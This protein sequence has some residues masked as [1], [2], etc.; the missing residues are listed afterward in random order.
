MNHNQ[1][2]D[3]RFGLVLNAKEKAALERLAERE[4]LSAA[5]VLR[6]LVMQAANPAGQPAQPHPSEV[7]R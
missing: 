7:T 2:R 6:R 3:E 1:K 5:A 4:N